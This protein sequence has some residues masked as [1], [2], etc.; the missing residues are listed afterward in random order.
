M[1]V[2]ISSGRGPA[3]CELAVGLY[4]EFFKRRHPRALV[5]EECGGWSRKLGDRKI[6]AYQSVLLELPEGEGVQTGAVKWC[7]PSPLRPAHGRKNW[8]IEVS[9]LNLGREEKI[10]AQGLDPDNPDRRLV[11]IETFHSSGKGGQNVNKVE[12]GVRAIHLPTGLTTTSTTARTQGRNR[13]LALE[14]LVMLILTHNLD[15]DRRQVS[16]GRQL[17]DQLER[18]N[19]FA[20]FTGL[21]FRAV[22]RL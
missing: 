11:R 6:T 22:E 14:R 4:L 2:Q 17:H 19:P 15:L 8:F 20:V 5:R 16:A 13:K 1:L 9:H 21:E 3:E 10:E 18:G 12:T 7:C